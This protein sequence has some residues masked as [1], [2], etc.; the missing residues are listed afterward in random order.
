MRVRSAV[1]RMCDAC[2]IVRRRGRIY[3]ICSA[4]RKVQQTVVLDNTAHCMQRLT[5]LESYNV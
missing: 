4:N 2:K 5:V 3:V 1:K